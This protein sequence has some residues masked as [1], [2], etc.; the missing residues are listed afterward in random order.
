MGRAG[1]QARSGPTS[2]RASL[3]RAAPGHGRPGQASSTRPCTLLPQADLAAKC[4]SAGRAA[5]RR[6]ED[7]R[8]PALDRRGELQGVLVHD[9][10][11][12][13][14][15]P[16][17]RRQ[18]HVRPLPARRRRP[19]GL[20]RPIGRHRPTSSSPTRSRRRWARGPPTRASARRT[21]P[22]VP[23]YKNPLPN[24]NGA[25][26]GPPDGGGAATRAKTTSAIARQA[27]REATQSSAAGVKPAALS[28][29]VSQPEPLRRGADAMKR[30][31]RKH[32]RDFAFV[33]GLVLVAAAR[34]RLHPLQPALL[35]AQVGPASWART[36]STTRP[37]SPPRSR[38]R[39]A[40]ARRSTSRACDVGDITKVDLVDG[41]A[42][43]T[44]KIRRKYTP[45]YKNATAL[46]RPKTGLNDMVIELDPGTPTAGE[47]PDGLHRPGRPDAAQRQLRRDP[48]LAGHATRAATCSCFSAPRARGST[49]RARR[50]RPRSSASSRPRATPAKINGALAVRRATSAA[51]I[52]NFR[53]LSQALGAK[54]DDLGGPRRLVQRGV[55]GVRRPGREPARDA[56]GS[57]PGAL[58]A[59]NTTLAKVDRAG[60]RARADARRAAARRPRARARRWCRRGRS[61]SRRRRSSR[62]SC[63]RSRARRCRSSRS[64]ARRP[65][66]WLSS[67]PS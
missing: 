22:T 39:R 21:S 33:I 55:Q 53:L 12:R 11:P 18:R 30:A 8:R 37:S 47:A 46:L 38:S 40:R 7:R 15:G 45:I 36:S 51:S 31:I 63:G 25:P 26:T 66:T 6:R 10:R 13:R 65:A 17:L 23:C 42:V 50:C 2:C 59:T 1:T 60:R 52:H 34:R 44:M 64:C 61:S 3:Q 16:E 27:A 9:G 4:V 41:R 48:V 32:A 43:V 56:A 57:C 35:P 5:D 24:L 58:Q 20:D 14:R 49:A 19:D 28:Q 54:D 62:T 67:R 29:V